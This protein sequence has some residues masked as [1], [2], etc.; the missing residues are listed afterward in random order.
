MQW[1][2]G[3]ANHS[4]QTQ[5]AACCSNTQMTIDISKDDRKEAIASIERYFQ[6]NMEEKIGNIAADGLL[7][8]FLR[9]I[10]PI[11]YNKAVAEVQECL[12]VRIMELDI[13]MHKDAF[14]YWRELDRKHKKKMAK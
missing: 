6:E 5:S 3:D 8:Y 7:D 2:V 12:G 4:S 10:G 14:Q 9:E 13:E 11:M 1:L